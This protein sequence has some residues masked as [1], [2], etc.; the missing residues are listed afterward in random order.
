MGSPSPPP[1][2]AS[3][4][5]RGW[6][7][8][9]HAPLSA[10]ATSLARPPIPRRA[11]ISR[12]STRA[13]HERS[14]TRAL[15]FLL[16]RDQTSPAPVRRLGSAGL[17][18]VSSSAGG[19]RACPVASDGGGVNRLHLLKAAFASLPSS[20]RH[21]GCRGGKRVLELPIWS[22]TLLHPPNAA[23]HV[24]R[25]DQVHS[26]MWVGAS[27][28]TFFHLFLRDSATDVQLELRR[29][30]S[31]TGM[32]QHRDGHLSESQVQRATARHHTHLPQALD[33]SHDDCPARQRSQS[34]SS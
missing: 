18:T 16:T 3:G 9:Y 28:D 6:C 1:S 11:D 2:G 7:E 30:N 14:V 15:L 31:G 19:L 32:C 26:C 27:R 34:S 20:A 25:P 13:R 10:S 22:P 33:A 12:L 24:L 17:L 29:S 5:R 8:S 23:Q 21:R 4:L